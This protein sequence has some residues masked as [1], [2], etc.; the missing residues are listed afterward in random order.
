MHPPETEPESEPEPSEFPYDVYVTYAEPDG[1]W[2]YDR[3]Y[4]RLDDV[5]LVV[6]TN[7][8]AFLPGVPLIQNI[9]QAISASRYVVAVLSPAHIGDRWGRYTWVSAISAKVIE[10]A[11]SDVSRRRFAAVV[12]APCSIP[13]EIKERW[14]YHLTEPSAELTDEGERARREHDERWQKLV[15]HLSEYGDEREAPRVRTAVMCRRIA[16]L[17]KQDATVAALIGHFHGR[18]APA[19]E[20]LGKL[21]QL[22]RVHDLLHEAL[23]SCYRPARAAIEGYPQQHSTTA[24]TSYATELDA[25]NAQLVEVTPSVDPLAARVWLPKLTGA[26]KAI[27]DAVE[28]AEAAD[29]AVEGERHP[30]RAEQAL[31]RYRKWAERQPKPAALLAIARP[32][33]LDFGRERLGKADEALKGVLP[34]QLSRVNVRLNDQA[35]SIRLDLLADIMDELRKALPQMADA[36]VHGDLAA[37]VEGLRQLGTRQAALLQLHDVWQGANN[38]LTSA[39]QQLRALADGDPADALG[40]LESDWKTVQAMLA[41]HL[42]ATPAK[43]QKLVAEERKIDLA[44]A[45]GRPNPAV[46]AFDSYCGHANRIF[47]AVDKQLLWLC[48]ALGGL[49]HQLS[50]IIKK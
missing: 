42:D 49:G 37:G 13:S 11:D 46:Q 7:D 9:S 28:L 10:S 20:Q 2:V 21:R 26:V 15:T 27:R 36:G 44:L 5:G 6:A 31:V 50:R 29:E 19:V 30:E 34:E 32:P 16:E 39:E 38:L 12:I 43:C 18:L 40:V 47:Y 41:P 14:C 25:L 8:T 35:R 22:K 48:D 17:S 3:L 23:M 4:K 1:Q 45:E 24:L 33:Y